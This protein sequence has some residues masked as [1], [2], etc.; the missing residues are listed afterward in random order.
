MKEFYN[1]LKR[2]NVACSLRVP[3]PQG[4]SKT[5]MQFL[6]ADFAEFSSREEKKREEKQNT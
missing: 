2:L 6:C 3:G 1:R 5:K 4:P